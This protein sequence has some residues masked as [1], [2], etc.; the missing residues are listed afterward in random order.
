M[1]EIVVFTGP[2][3]HDG[4]AAARLAELGATV[5]PPVAQGDVA[6][7]VALPE[8]DRPRVIGIIDG[9][10]ERVPAV[11]HK[12]ILWALAEGIAVA[13]AASMGALRAAELAPFGMVG[14]GRVHAAVRS[15]ELVDDDEVAVAHLGPDDGHR[16]VSDAM[17]DIRATLDAALAAAV[18]DAPAARTIADAAK[19]LHY[20]E[21]RWPHLLS[22]DPTGALARWLPT[23]RVSV[24][25]ADAVELLDLLPGLP[26]PTVRFH[27][28]PTEQWLAARPAPGTGLLDP[29][30]FER[31]IE[32]LHR[33]GVYEDLERAA[34]L[35]LVAVR[36][37]GGLRPH[38]AALDE[39]TDRV[40]AR[41][42]AADLDGFG[43][44]ALAGFAADQACL[45]AACDHGDAEIRAA[46][47]DTLRVRGEYARRVAEARRSP[48][49][50]A[51]PGEEKEDTP[52]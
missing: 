52:R 27:L 19:A 9:V 7:L 4:A 24:K 18:I 46:L 13:G 14:A 12:E 38:G 36:H 29:G 32:G 40:R 31:L 20:T 33:D 26:P 5:L 42:G 34:T 16:P 47:L 2:T 51:D 49:R 8:K 17:V 15:G 43:P 37:A 28:E 41:I 44:A 45:V 11:W 48:D 1:S 3:C 25:A 39:W 22:R 50:F 35:R 23:G 10:Y 6:R 30:T 21:R